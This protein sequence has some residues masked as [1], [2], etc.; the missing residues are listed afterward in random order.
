MY[1]AYD[2]PDDHEP[3]IEAGKKLRYADF[4][5]RHLYCYVLIGFPKDNFKDAERR[6]IQTWSAG[7]MPMAMLWKNKDG[8]VNEEW[9]K[10]Q[11]LWARPA[12]IRTR[13]KNEF[14]K[15]GHHENN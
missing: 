1:F 15:W 8:D 12:I 6:L 10:F 13:M 3:L 7:F 2:T 9:R 4:T 5:R 14:K 11:R